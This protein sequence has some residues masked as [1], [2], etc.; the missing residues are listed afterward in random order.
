MISSCKNFILLIAYSAADFFSKRSSTPD[1][2][3][4]RYI[5]TLFI[6]Y[7]T[8]ICQEHTPKNLS[9]RATLTNLI[10]EEHAMRGLCPKTQTT[11]YQLGFGLQ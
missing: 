11:L 3:S 6:F 7:S 1:S 4:K 5:G 2:A 8:K 10:S 9:H